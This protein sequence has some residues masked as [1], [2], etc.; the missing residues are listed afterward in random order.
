MLRVL[1]ILIVNDNVGWLCNIN[2]VDD[3]ILVHNRCRI[4]NERTKDNT[5][6][7]INITLR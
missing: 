1:V 7:R 5:I 4:Q 3:L 2:S 6:W